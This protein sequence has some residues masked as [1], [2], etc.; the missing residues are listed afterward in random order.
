MATMAAME[1]RI[2]PLIIVSHAVVLHAGSQKNN[3]LGEETRSSQD[4]A[5]NSALGLGDWQLEQASF[6]ARRMSP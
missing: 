6:E 4:T 3:T 5:R 2:F 1:A